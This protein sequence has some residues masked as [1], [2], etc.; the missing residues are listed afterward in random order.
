MVTRL[1]LW[2][3][4]GSHPLTIHYEEVVDQDGGLRQWIFV[5]DGSWR[6]SGR[7]ATDVAGVAWICFDAH[8][9][10]VSQEAL[11]LHL[12]LSPLMAEAKACLE[13]I[14]WAARRKLRK[15]I[16]TN[17]QVLVRLLQQKGMEM[18]WQ[19]ALIIND[20]LYYNNDR[21]LELSLEFQ[22]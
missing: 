7:Q 22:N 10:L 3:I 16:I 18:E 1:I 20:I 12:T 21:A 11:V 6:N 9:Q 4:C 17:C 14:R 5:I 8:N 2:R 13:A 15:L 19:V